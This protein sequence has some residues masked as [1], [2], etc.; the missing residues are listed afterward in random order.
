MAEEGGGWII[1][2]EQII[3]RIWYTERLSYIFSDDSAF[4]KASVHE[5]AVTCKCPNALF[6]K[7]KLPHNWPYQFILLLSVS[8]GD[9]LPSHI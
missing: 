7:V 9:G 6:S 2:H 8:R 5:L 4:Q 3:R 1:H